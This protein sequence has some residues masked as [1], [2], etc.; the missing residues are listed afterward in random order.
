MRLK[1][2]LYNILFNF[3]GQGVTILLG[4]LIPRLFLVS[5]GSEM[6]GLLNSVS[7]LLAYASLLEVGIGTASLQSL[8]SPVEKGDREK[9]S[10]IMSATGIFYRKIAFAVTIGVLAVA[11]SYPYFI[12]SEIPKSTVTRVILFNSAPYVAGLYVQSKYK[13]LLEAEGKLYINANLSTVL[14]ILTNFCK[15]WLLMAGADVLTVQFSYMAIN[16]FQVVYFA[17]YAK[18]HYSWVNLKA[19]P[20]FSAIAQRNS[21]LIH[22]I[23][24]VIFRNTDVLILTAIQGLKSASVYSLYQLFLSMIST[25]LGNI[26]SGFSFILAQTFH[27]DREKYLKMHDVVE[28]YYMTLTFLLYTVAYLCLNPFMALYTRG[29]TDIRYVDP[30]LPFLF[31]F[32][33]LLSA[34]REKSCD[35]INYAQHFR[36]TKWRAVAEAI[37]NLS[38]SILCVFR[39]GIYGVL[40]GTIAALLYRTND[41]ILY[42]NRKILHRSPWIT[43]RRWL[44]NFAVFALA[45]LAGRFVSIPA[46]NYFQLFLSAA[47]IFVILALLY[48]SVI[49]LVERQVFR[50]TLGFAVKI[51]KPRFHKREG[52]K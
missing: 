19:K 24:G 20:D 17:R 48:F 8:Y 40:F 46:E 49:S 44:V 18:K 1:R 42:A 29:I 31:V 9:V 26:S 3:I 35:V 5:F 51:I 43:Y 47:V 15:V 21:V 14:H 22:K 28:T 10:A 25:A 45:A 37:I 12:K 13:I 27:S 41:I 34:G 4:V 52:R 2:G 32:T 30:W 16:L 33:F 7:Q 38:V 6:N 39:F 50:D 11:F 36:Q 23:S